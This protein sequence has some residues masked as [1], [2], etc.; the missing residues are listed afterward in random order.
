MRYSYIEEKKTK[1]LRIA[2]QTSAVQI[3]KDQK[4]MQN[5]EYFNCLGSM[6]TSDAICTYTCS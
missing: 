1:V 3:A 6:I 4:Q 5:M 2:R